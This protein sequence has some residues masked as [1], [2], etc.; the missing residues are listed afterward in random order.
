MARATSL[1]RVI[2]TLEHL[3]FKVTNAYN[4]EFYFETSKEHYVVTV[5]VPFGG[6][7]P[8]GAVYADD[9]ATTEK[10]DA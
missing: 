8:D 1:G 7:I 10:E 6:R 2:E 5:V 3:G 4:P 9:L